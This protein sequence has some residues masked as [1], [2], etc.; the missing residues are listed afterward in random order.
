MKIKEGDEVLPMTTRGGQMIPLSELLDRMVGIVRKIVE[1]KNPELPP[2]QKD[3]VAEAV[4]VGAIIFWVQARRRDSNIVFDWKQATN[5]DGDTGPYVQYTHARA[6][7]I[8]RKSGRSVPAAADLALLREPEEAAVAKAL[9][10]F[11]EVLQQAAAGYEPSVLG[12]W[13][14]ETSR[15]FNDFYNKHQVLKA[16]TEAL[17]DARLVLVD[18]VRSALAGGLGL[19][20]VAAPEEM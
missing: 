19:L 9:E 18:A 7:S 10:R 11:P 1:E 15:A 16:E 17:R 4:G 13:L 6:C 14:L 2:A 12:T 5:P 3:V 20:G 8:L